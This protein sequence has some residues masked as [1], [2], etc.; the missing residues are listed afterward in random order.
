MAAPS[1]PVM[2]KQTNRRNDAVNGGA[3]GRF[4][5]GAP[6]GHKDTMTGRRLGS[7]KHRRN[8]IRSYQHFVWT[9]RDRLPLITS[10]IEQYVYTYIEVVCRS[11]DCPVLAIGGMPDHVHL[12]VAF[13]ATLTYAELM[14][15]VKGGSSRFVTA[16][17]LP[18]QWFAWRANYAV[19][20]VSP[21]DKVA[22]IAYISCQKEHHH[23]NKLW[24]SVEDIDEPEDESPENAE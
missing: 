18:G 5:P 2:A 15:R 10:A 14:N 11:I 8:K 19:F 21:R 22:T 24:P 17:L 12:L 9:T 1:A 16:K 6:P 3:R 7:M 4:A 20:S 13:P 23:N